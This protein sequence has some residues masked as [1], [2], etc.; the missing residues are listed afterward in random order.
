MNA[1]TTTEAQ[2]PLAALE[3]DSV[4]MDRQALANIL[5]GRVAIDSKGNKIVLLNGV[6]QQATNTQ[7]VALVILAQRALALRSREKLPAGLRPNEISNITG[8]AGN[9]ARPSIKQLA[10]DGLI[11]KQKD[12]TYAAPPH[13]LE[14][15]GHLLEDLATGQREADTN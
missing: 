2:D 11:I 5:R 4:E 3:V 14:R 10:D 7:L 6:R 8:V 12:G 9:S 13:A 1:T 15:L